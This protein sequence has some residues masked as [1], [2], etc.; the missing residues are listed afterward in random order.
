MYANLKHTIR[1][2]LSNAYPENI[3][4]REKIP[5]CPFPINPCPHPPKGNYCFDFFPHRLVLLLPEFHRFYNI[6]YSLSLNHNERD[7]LLYQTLMPRFWY[8]FCLYTNNPAASFKQS[9]LDGL[10]NLYQFISTWLLSFPGLSTE[11][12][13]TM[14]HTNIHNLT[15]PTA[16]GCLYLIFL[17]LSQFWRSILLLMSTLDS[18]FPKEN[19][20]GPSDSFSRQGLGSWHLLFPP[21]D[22]RFLLDPLP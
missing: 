3:S 10:H 13:S 5:S 2:I 21:K 4:P 20:C 15:H 18:Y 22:H 16:Q 1:G 12:L 7:T 17:P 14:S 11:I 6:F 9:H 19:G 8:K